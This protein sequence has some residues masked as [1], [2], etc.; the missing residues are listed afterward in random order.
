MVPVFSGQVRRAYARN[1]FG[2]EMVDGVIFGVPGG[3]VPGSVI[4]ALNA[5]DLPGRLGAAYPEVAP[6]GDGVSFELTEIVTFDT[7]VELTEDAGGEKKRFH[8]EVGLQLVRPHDEEERTMID[9][10]K[11]DLDLLAPFLLRLFARNMRNWINAPSSD[12]PISE[13]ID[14]A[15]EL[16]AVGVSSQAAVVLGTALERDLRQRAAA[17]PD[18]GKLHGAMLGKLIATAKKAGKIADGDASRMQAFKEVRNRCAHAVADE[19]EIDVRDEVE[20][21][22]AWFG[23]FRLR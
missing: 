19:A 16:V 11:G 10:A 9:M 7:V 1:R 14:Y 8:R 2:R 18:D 20:R 22:I 21:F 23:E 4:R 13:L 5:I 15:R 12:A 17:D 6:I 3:T